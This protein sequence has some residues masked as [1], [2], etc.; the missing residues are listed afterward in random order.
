M[1][2]KAVLPVAGLGTRF[3]TAT[4]VVPKEIFPI[5]DKP[6]M[7]II[8]NEL[9]NNGIDEILLVIRDGKEIIPNHFEKNL[10]LE[11][12]LLLNNK[13][14]L[15]NLVVNSNLSKKI[16]VVK[17][18]EPNGLADAIYY[19]KDFVG[20]EPFIVCTG[21][22]LVVSSGK[23]SIGQMIDCYNQVNNCVVGLSYTD[24]EDLCNYG[25]VDFCYKNNNILINDIVE[26]PIYNAPSNFSLNGKYIVDGRIFNIIDNLRSS[27]IYEVLFTDCL[28]ALKGDLYGCIIQGERCDTGCRFGYLKANILYALKDE[29]L[30]CKV[31]KYLEK[32]LKN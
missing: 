13:R 31:K 15:Y 30:S 6:I 8:V 7:E 4:K 19:A 3:L 28:M 27:L 2:K 20:N 18:K 26:K 23:D 29:D 5:I 12:Y 24:V 32:I 21:D 9:I 1:I 11:Q 22:E 16:R 17:Q 25:I 14:E 10:P